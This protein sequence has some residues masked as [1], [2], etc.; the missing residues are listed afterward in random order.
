VTPP[1]GRAT[2]APAPGAAA[3]RLAGKTAIVVGAGQTPGEN[4]GNGRAIALLFARAGARVMCVDRDLDRAAQTAAQIEA[5]GGAAFAHRADV[6]SRE[7]CAAMVD[8]ARERW[9]RIDVLV[10]DVGIG[11]GGDGPAHRAD[12]AAWDRILAVNLKGTWLTIRQALPLM[13]EQP[14]GGAIV[15][16]SSLASLA[17][18]DMVAYE[19]SKAGVN[20]LT[21][22]VASANARHGVRCNAV[23]PGFIDTPM[24]VDAAARASGR[25]VDEVRRARDAMVPLR[26]R[27]GSGWDTAY[28][29]LYLA[30]DE[31]AFVTGALLLVDGGM[32][33]RMG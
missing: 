7:D 23:L 31:A 30:S 12:E 9:G 21:T 17:G 22:S 27:M 1:G 8:A 18:K 10:N 15:N 3:G 2:G 29:A 16:V 25:P 11:G 32:S 4:V 20:R 33:V 26:G 28:A 14:G 19:V 5:E 6:T 24:A 13:R